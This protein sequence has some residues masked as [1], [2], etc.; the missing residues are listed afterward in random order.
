MTG[1]NIGW[2]YYFQIETEGFDPV[3]TRGFVA[4]K[5]VASPVI[6]LEPSGE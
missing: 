6:R 4:E 2:I 1:S 5:N 3:E